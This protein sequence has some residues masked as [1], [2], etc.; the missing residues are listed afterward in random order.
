MA[1]VVL[2]CGRICC[3]KTTYAQTLCKD[4]RAVL[5]S[6]DEIMLGIFGQHCGDRHDEY[7]AGT[8]KYLYAK[9]LELLGA[10]IDVILDWGFWTGEVRS[11]AKEY[12][13]YKI[14]K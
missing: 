9:S 13:R 7:A 6:V 2:I 14:S 10:G 8:Q 4:R 3:G 12:Y 5:L 11:K 1:D